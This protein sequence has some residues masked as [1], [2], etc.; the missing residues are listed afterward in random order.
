MKTK[1]K[2]TFILM[3]LSIIGIFSFLLY[4]K[5]P[6]DEKYIESKLSVLIEGEDGKY[7]ISPDNTWPLEGYIFNDED[8][9]C[10][11]NSKLAWNEKTK[12]INLTAKN[13]D[14]CYVIFDVDNLGNRCKGEK[15]TTCLIN[16]AKNDSTLIYHNLED[17]KNKNIPNAEL[18]ANDDSYRYSGASDKVN[19]YV[20]LDG[21][22]TKGSCESDN[23]LYRIIGLFKNENGEY[24]VKLIKATIPTKSELGDY[25]LKGGTY[26]G[27]QSGISRYFWNTKYLQSSVNIWQYSNFNEFNLNSFY[28]N[29]LTS[30]IPNLINKVTNHNWTVGGLRVYGNSAKITYDYDIGENKI[31]IGDNYCYAEDDNQNVRACQEKDVV[32]QDEIGLMYIS[33]YGYATY[34]DAWDKDLYSYDKE[35]IRNNNWLFLNTPS[36]LEWTISRDSVTSHSIWVVYDSGKIDYA[37]GH[38]FA[39]TAAIGRPVFY[40]DS[41]TKLAS[42]DGSKTYP[43]RL[44]DN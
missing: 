16:N 17:A 30:T 21:N 32:F 29:H 26:H 2:I 5:K 41:S 22:D 38:V 11:N 9:Y 4:Y 18:V 20:C 23:D 7:K 43:Y 10:E 12:G 3:I 15:I 24:E 6:K 40:L 28:Y 37:Y 42:G 36:V 1:I 25:S 27:E 14:K 34:P 31:N 44:L 8:S 13:S 39:S 35:E 19:N 33:D